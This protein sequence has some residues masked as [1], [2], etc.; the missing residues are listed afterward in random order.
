MAR[1]Y[2]GNVF[3]MNKIRQDIPGALEV[4]MLHEMLADDVQFIPSREKKAMRIS[5]ERYCMTC[6]GSIKISQRRRSC[7]YTAGGQIYPKLL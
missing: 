7:N 3:Y 6:R 5:N 2:C 1:E 4:Y